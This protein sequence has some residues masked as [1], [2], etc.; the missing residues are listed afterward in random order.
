VTPDRT[1]DDTARIRTILISTDREFR[2]QMAEVMARPGSLAEPVLALENTF[3][4]IGD[5]ELARIRDADGGLVVVDLESD[6]HIGLKFIQYLIES[7]TAPV[8]VAA[9]REFSQDLLLQAM[10]AG[11]TELLAKPVTPEQV[12]GAL[13]R[14]WKKTGR[15]AQEAEDRTEPG[16]ALAIF[17]TKGG[18]GTT[19]LATN[20]AIEIHRMT[21]KRVLL[22]DL[23]VELGETALMLGMDPQFSLMDLSR[24]FHRVD[25]G[26]LASYIEHHESGIDLLAAPFQPADYET[27][28]RDRIRQVIRFLRGQYDYLVMDTPKSFHPAS[29][30][31]LEEAD[32]IYLLSTPTLPAIRNLVRSLPLVRQI[33]GQERVPSIRLV[34]NRYQPGSLISIKEIE[35]TVGLKVVHWIRNDFEAVMGGINEGKPAVLRGGSAYAKGVRSLAGIVTGTK[36]QEE[37][38]RGLLAG[39]VGAFRNG[40]GKD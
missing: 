20:L 14:V 27:V 16:R 40:K 9:G 7:G 33:V 21:R 18:A 29:I 12:E 23:D 37:E 3:T 17:G 19:A 15:K 36:I 39:L 28:S 10:Q 25:A 38:R 24:N 35:E 5:V 4:E 13:Q 8:V 30:G 22:L 34:V 32:E 2:E 31:V 11:V 26:L 1:S 6:P